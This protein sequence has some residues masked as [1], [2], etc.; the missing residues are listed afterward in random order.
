LRTSATNKVGNER[1]RRYVVP[2]QDVVI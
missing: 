2:A 1:E